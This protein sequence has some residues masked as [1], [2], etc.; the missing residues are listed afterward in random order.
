[1][2]APATQTTLTGLQNN[3]T[4]R[5]QVVASQLPCLDPVTDPPAPTCTDQAP[6]EQRE[7]GPVSNAVTF[8][9]EI[10]TTDP[11]ASMQIN[12]GAAWTTEPVVET[13][14][15]ATDASPMR[16]LLGLGS[17]PACGNPATCGSPYSENPSFTLTGAD[18]PKTVR[19]R[20][21]DAAGNETEAFDTINLDTTAPDLWGSPNSLEVEPGDTVQFSTKEATDTGSG[22]DE[23]SFAWSFCDG[24]APSATG[25]MASR[26]F[27]TAGNFLVSLTA[28]DIAG[29]QGVDSFVLTVTPPGPGPGGGASAEPT[30]SGTSTGAT[31]TGRTTSRVLASIG[32]VGRAKVGKPLRVR[33]KLKRKVK[34]VI[35]VLSRPG[36]DQSLLKRFKPRKAF[37]KG[38]TVYKLSAPS[39]SA[40][41]V[42]RVTAGG[43][44]KTLIFLIHR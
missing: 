33:V 13:G 39:R 5:V 44:T 20:V 37:R 9:V 10:D 24:C 22:L 42:L 16:M 35:D 18:G 21:V 25:R 6:E 27:N 11:V 15:S 38:A 17:A 34:V 14:L 32:I 40:T 29:N 4:Y 43:E 12:G 30:G 41:R 28:R 1:V 23:S 36:Q 19:A 8:R 26:T 31:T 2:S 7:S 3:A